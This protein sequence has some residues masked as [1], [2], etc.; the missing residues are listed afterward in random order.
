[1][2]RELAAVA[3]LYLV[4]HL[5]YLPPTLEDIDSINF[6][7]GVRDFD[8]ARHQPHPPGYPAAP[9]VERISPG[10]WVKAG[11]GWRIW[12]L[13][14]PDADPGAEAGFTGSS[15]GVRASAGRSRSRNR[16]ARNDE[17]PFQALSSNSSAVS[18]LGES[19]RV[20][21]CRQRLRRRGW[22]R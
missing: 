17:K 19:Q 2:K 15:G 6:A 9:M 12:P 1:V 7:L 13:P 22:S 14:N 21:I 5:L 18:A 11:S 8:V 16:A 20:P 10:D 3:V 4:A